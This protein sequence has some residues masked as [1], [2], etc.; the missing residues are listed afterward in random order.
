MVKA[1]GIEGVGASVLAWCSK[2]HQTYGD[3]DFQDA[4]GILV[5]TGIGSSTC[6]LEDLKPTLDWITLNDMQFG[7]DEQL[8]I[9]TNGIQ[10]PAREKHGVQRLPLLMIH[11]AN[12]L[13]MKNSSGE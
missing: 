13:M 12:P 10:M 9:H 8:F 7:P 6:P 4:M 11:I 3:Q 1:L 2:R 5:V